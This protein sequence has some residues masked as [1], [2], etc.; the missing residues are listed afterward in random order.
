MKFSLPGLLV[1]YLINGSVALIWLVA[2]VPSAPQGLDPLFLA[3]G[4]YVLGMLVDFCAWGLTFIPKIFIRSW[5]ISRYKK[6]EKHS[7]GASSRRKIA[8]QL[9]NSDLAAEYERRSSRDRVARGTI[10][11]LILFLSTCPET[12][13]RVWTW[14]LLA[15]SLL[16]WARF[17]YASFTY[18]IEARSAS[19][20]AESA[21][22][23]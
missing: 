6:K 7:I 4:I 13:V 11:N 15:L 3:P 19:K 5:V 8:L 2:L 23:D 22:R 12:P 20:E 21:G 10:V 17:E 18:S 14:V 16:M 1:E 9:E